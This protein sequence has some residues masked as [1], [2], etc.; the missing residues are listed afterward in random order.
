MSNTQKPRGLRAALKDRKVRKT[1]YDI[2]IVDHEVAQKASEELD[3]VKNVERAGEYLLSREPENAEQLQQAV[4][5]AQREIEKATERLHDCFYRVWFVGMPEKDFDK[6]VNDFPP[7]DEQKAEARLRGEDE[8]VWDE[9]EF[10][11]HLLERCAQESE[12]TAE[13]WKAETESWTKAERR[14][15]IARVV[16]CNIRSFSSTISFG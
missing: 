10:P 9:D 15:L 12:L 13:E 4:E 11:F 2:P 6:L 3:V 8:P 5:A 14:E 7:S 1:Y 16:E